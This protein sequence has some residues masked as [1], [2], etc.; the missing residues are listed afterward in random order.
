MSPHIA[1]N[2][3]SKR[4]RAPRKTWHSPSPPDKPQAKNPKP[5]KFTPV[6]DSALH[7]FCFPVDP[8]DRGQ[9]GDNYTW[10]MRERMAWLVMG[11]LQEGSADRQ[12]AE[13]RRADEIDWKKYRRR[14]HDSPIA[15]ERAAMSQMYPR[16]FAQRST[17]TKDEA[18]RL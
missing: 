11:F 10:R 1:I 8:W 15:I 2:H 4:D 9:R 7:N 13:A 14:N 6:L 3:R 17:S 12:L 16:A 5:C 18:L